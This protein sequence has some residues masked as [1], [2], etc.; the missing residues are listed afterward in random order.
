MPINHSVADIEALK[1]IGSSGVRTNGYLKQVVLPGDG[2]LSAWYSFVASSSRDALG[3][4]VVMPDDLPTTGRWYK[5]SG[6]YHYDTS[7]PT[8]APPFPSIIWVAKLTAPTRRVFYLSVGVG[9][10]ADWIPHGDIPIAG[11]GTP[12]FNPDYIGQIFDDETGN[13]LYVSTGLTSS[14]W[15]V[16]PGGG[17]GGS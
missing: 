10:V 3:N 15:G 12:N 5:Q 7:R 2:E 11:I 13:K 9:S 16:A 6:L 17:G 4:I 14:S 8:A 1:A